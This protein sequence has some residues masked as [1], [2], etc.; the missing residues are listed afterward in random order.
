MSDNDDVL[1]ADSGCDQSIVN[2]VW[3]I[4]HDTGRQIIVNGAL[5]RRH[6]GTA[7]PVVTAV[8]KIIDN[9]GKAW[10]ATLHEAL[11]DSSPLQRESLLASAQVRAADNALDDCDRN[12][13]TTTGGYST[14]CTIVDGNTVPF[15]FNGLHCYYQVQP[16][17]DDEIQ[18]LPNL[19]FTNRDR[20]Y[21]PT[22]RF[23]TRRTMTYHNGLLDWKAALGFPP[24]N[25]VQKTLQAT[26][27]Y[28]PSIESETREIMRDHF[29]SRFPCFKF[30]R[31]NSIICLDT[32]FSSVKSIRGYTCFNLY[33]C[34]KSGYDLPVLMH[35][36]SQLPQTIMTFVK[37]CGI[38]KV[39]P[40]DNAPEFKGR[41][42]QKE[43]HRLIIDTTL[44]EP[45]HPNQNTAER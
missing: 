44:T 23:N 11:Y 38:P 24:D 20:P 3:R 27:Q 39:I 32:F 8:A 34:T 6:P 10:Q 35:R 26:T 5:A 40:S 33:S 2:H 41:Q 1:I 21:E 28:V 16:I 7:F 31:L 30:R 42:F 45:H 13:P 9:D 37:K 12:S 29:A 43:L 18:T 36:R 19:V 22:R 25:V 14:Q 4:I 17:T 15:L